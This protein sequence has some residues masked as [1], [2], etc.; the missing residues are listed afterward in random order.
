VEFLRYHTQR[1]ILKHY[2]IN[3]D[4]SIIFIFLFFRK[5]ALPITLVIFILMFAVRV[6]IVVMKKRGILKRL[7]EKLGGNRITKSGSYNT[8]KSIIQIVIPTQGHSSWGT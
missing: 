5:I 1:L 2:I 3:T 7:K 8:N 4:F 6:L